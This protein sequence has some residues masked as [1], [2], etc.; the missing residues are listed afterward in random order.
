VASRYRRHA[1][2]IV[3]CLTNSVDLVGGPG[4]RSPAG[5]VHD[6]S[7]RR[8]HQ[9]FGPADRLRRWMAP[10]I[11]QSA[12]TPEFNSPT[13]AI[14][15]FTKRP[16]RSLTFRPMA[17]RSLSGRLI[18]R[19][20][21]RGGCDDVLRQSKPPSP[22]VRRRVR[23]GRADVVIEE[24]FGRPARSAFR[25]VPTARPRSPRLGAGPQAGVR[26]RRGPTPRP[27]GGGGGGV[28]WG[29]WPNSPTPFVKNDEIHAEILG[30]NHCFRR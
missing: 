15:R 29:G 8:R 27:G 13:G 4:S 2:V 25:A 22:D 11:Y 6:E 19:R 23:R 14:C 18:G 20:Q 16:T 10:R 7:R 26:S 17:R 24:F 5:I 3:S 9:A 30:K 1:A 12:R 28:G 21:G